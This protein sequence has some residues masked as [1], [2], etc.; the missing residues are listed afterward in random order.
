MDNKKKFE[1]LEKKVS[2]LRE[3]IE[4]LP[5]L[6]DAELIQKIKIIKCGNSAHIPLSKKHLGKEATVI[7]EKNQEETQ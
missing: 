4:N 1:D 7:I 6:R 2:S 5:I 3:T